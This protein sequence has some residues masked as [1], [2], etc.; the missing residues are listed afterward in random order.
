MFSAPPIPRPTHTIRSALVRSTP[1]SAGATASTNV[2]RRLSSSAGGASWTRSPRPAPCGSSCS[3][4]RVDGDHRRQRRARRWRATARR[5]RRWSPPPRRRRAT[6]RRSSRRTAGRAGRRRGGE[7]IAR[8]RVLQQDEVRAARRDRRRE[9]RLVRLGEI[10]GRAPGAT[11]SST[12]S[13]AVSRS[14]GDRSPPATSATSSPPAASAS[15]RA[16]ASSR[17]LI[18]GSIYTSTSPISSPELP[19]RAAPRRSA[20]PPVRHH[21]RASSRLVCGSGRASETSSVKPAA[22]PRR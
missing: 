21:P 18:E 3:A 19:V 8:G 5:R 2:V 22:G 6:S 13:A 10:R 12:T 4:A 7:V 9:H 15:G 1:S 14:I 20:P 16:N 11:T 17:S